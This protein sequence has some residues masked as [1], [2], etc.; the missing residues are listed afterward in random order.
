MHPYTYPQIPVLLTATVTSPGFKESPFSTLSRDG[1]ASP[2]HNSCC[3][4]VYTP[5]LAFEIFAITGTISVAEGAI[6]SA[7]IV[8]E[9]FIKCL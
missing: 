8:I 7:L 2:T 3:G 4:F 6:V 5:I 1:Y 9:V